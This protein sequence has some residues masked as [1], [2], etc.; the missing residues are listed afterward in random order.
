MKRTTNRTYLILA[1]GLAL[2]LWSCDSP[3]PATPPNIVWIVLEDMSPQFIGAYGNEA[4]RT[5]VMDSLINTGTK[6]NAAFS[7]GAVC[8]PSRYTIITGTRTNAYGTGHHRS[9]YPIPDTVKAFPYFLKKAGY[10]TTNCVKKD[11]NTS[12]RHR[13]AKE[14]WVESSPTAGWW[15]RKPNQ[16]FFSVFNFNNSHQSRTFTNPYDNYKGRILDHLSEDE[17]IPDEDIIL[18]S[19]YKDTPEMRRE[20]ARTYNALKKVDNEIDTLLSRLKKENLMESTIILIYSD[21]GGGSLRTKS[22][23]LPLGHQVPMAV[24]VPDAY[25]HLDPFDG[26]KA[27]DQPVT[28]EDL[29]PTVLAL[30]GLQKADYMSGNAFLGETFVTHDYTFS[31][32]DRCGESTDLTRSVTNGRYFY[33]RVFYPNKPQYSWQKYFDYSASRELIRGYVESDNLDMI[34]QAPFDSRPV[35]FLFDLEND[36]WQTSNLAENQEYAKIK[37]RLARELDDHLL[38]VKDVMFLPEYLLDS[39][40]KHTT[41][42]EYKSSPDYDFKSIYEAAQLVGKGKEAIEKQLSAIESQ[43][44]VVRYWGYV[45]LL[46][47]KAQDIIPHLNRVEDGLDDDFAPNQILTAA[48]LFKLTQ[49]EKA[50]SIIQSFL[51]H[52]NY[53]LANQAIQEVLYFPKNLALSFSE[54]IERLRSQKTKYELSE[55]IDIYRYQFFGE[56]LYY[57]QHW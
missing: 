11:Y 16:P 37:K 27:T 15:S 57:A 4:A 47:Q 2:S 17:R 10:H 56:P 33:T 19:F 43:N 49:G 31:S 34:Q 22:Q 23:G 36:R 53:L 41:P 25:R 9:N 38:E 6:F 35:E 29:A 40:A 18:P 54:D 26:V 12:D 1:V 8:S 52:N 28:F 3:K 42:F 5:P 13:L 20:L 39:I 55:S 51:H 30:A 21:H 48:A 50:K 7:T 44:A 14:A 45:G 24:I 32:T 46:N